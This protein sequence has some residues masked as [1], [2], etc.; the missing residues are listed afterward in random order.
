MT[1]EEERKEKWGFR[2]GKTMEYGKDPI[3]C[4]IFECE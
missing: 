1:E 3:A 2:E 4:W